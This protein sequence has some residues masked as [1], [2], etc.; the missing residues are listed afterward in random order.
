MRQLVHFL[1]SPVNYI[2]MAIFVLAGCT[3][4]ENSLSELSPTSQ[5][6]AKVATDWMALSVELTME[7]PGYTSPIATRAFA[8]FGIAIYETVVMGIDGQASLQG[9]INGLPAYHL[10]AIQ[11]DGEMNWTLAVNDCMNYLFRKF[12]RN[13][14]PASLKKIQDLYNLHRSSVPDH[15]NPNVLNK[16][17]QFGEMM[18]KAIYEYSITDGQE[19]AFLNNYP[20]NYSAPT[21]Q[22]LWSPTSQVKKPLLPYW[23]NVRTFT[24][25][26]EFTISTPPSFST[27]SNST[28]FSYAM[29]VRNRVKNLDDPIVTM[30]KYWNDDQDKSL[31]VSGHI[32]SILIDLI[33]KEQKDLAFAAKSIARLG[34]GLHDATVASW[35]VKY[36]YNMLRPETY[37]REN[38]D[39]DFISLINSQATPEYSSSASAIGMAGAEILGEIFG[40]NYAFTDRT[41]EN[42]KDID[43]TP[44]S[45]PSFQHMAEEINNSNLYGGIHYRFSLEA[46]QQQGNLIGK[47]INRLTM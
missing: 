14:P 36:H 22:G 33:V 19:E 13:A 47:N 31:S 43:G 26:S 17:C 21:G 2:V 38:I 16:S 20:T 35:K 40:Y 44:R 45:Y 11:G 7:T 24:N 8:Y 30:V 29:E 3:K 10:P 6:S 32:I 25:L 18:G 46:G 27:S 15:M 9:R 23:G 4:E 39:K 41:H 34:M 12:Y 1:A 42:R 37:I 5:E 28:F